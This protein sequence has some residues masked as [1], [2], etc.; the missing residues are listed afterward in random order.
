MYKIVRYK[1][2]TVLNEFKRTKIK[3]VVD[4]ELPIEFDT[5]TDAASHIEFKL[6]GK[7]LPKKEFSKVYFTEKEN[8]VWFDGVYFYSIFYQ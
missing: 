6:K 1:N 4:A 7:Y 3:T 2:T 5:Y 8:A